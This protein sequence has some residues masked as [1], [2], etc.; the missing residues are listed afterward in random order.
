MDDILGCQTN[1][2]HGSIIEAKVVEWVI[3]VVTN[4]DELEANLRAA[5]AKQLTMLAP[6]RTVIE[7]TDKL[8]AE[9]QH[10][11]AENIAL[12]LLQVKVELTSQNT[13]VATCL[14]PVQPHVIDSLTL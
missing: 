7:E 2:I 1:G 5:Q 13:A 6:A 3:S 14:L 4:P 12:N 11:L 9:A 8:I 10:D